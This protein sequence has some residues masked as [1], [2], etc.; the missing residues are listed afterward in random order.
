MEIVVLIVIIA[1]P[2]V[3]LL[4]WLMGQIVSSSSDD[5]YDDVERVIL[6]TEDIRSILSD[7]GMPEEHISELLRNSEL[8]IYKSVITCVYT[9]NHIIDFYK[10]AGITP[11]EAPE[12]IKSSVIIRKCIWEHLLWAD[13][14][15]IEYCISRTILEFYNKRI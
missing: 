3:I 2:V 5:D 8:G 1:I 14:K 13:K 15:T 12:D 4:V 10:K 7:V 9:S 11:P 6:D